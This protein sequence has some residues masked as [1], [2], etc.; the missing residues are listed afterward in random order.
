MNEQEKFLCENLKACADRFVSA[1]IY[2]VLP[3]IGMNIGYTVDGNSAVEVCDIPG[4]IRRVEND[5]CYVREPKMGGSVYMAQTLLAIRKKFPQAQCVANLRS[6]EKILAACRELDFVMVDMPT[7]PGY[8]QLG[9]DYFVDLEKVIAECD[10]LPDVIT[11]PD[12]INLEKLILV[13]SAD[14][15]DF[16]DKVLALNSMV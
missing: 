7:P 2:K 8:W 13:V 10:D 6:S 14:L 12:R 9:N 5:C 1:N 15:E 11:I 4:R 3:E 16:A